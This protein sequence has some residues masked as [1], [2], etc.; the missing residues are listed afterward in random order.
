MTESKPLLVNPVIERLRA[1]DVAMGINIRMS[2]SSDIVRIAKTTG[3][4]FIFIDTQHALFDLQAIGEM[5]HTAQAIGVCPLVRVRSVDD[6]DVSL[7]LDC[8]VQG[9]VFPDVNN[10]AMARKGVETC[11]FAPRGKRSVGGGYMQFDYRALP[12]DQ[13]IG[14]L[15]ESTLVICMIETVE[16]LANVEEIAAVKGVDI[17]HLGT[18][19]LL[20]NMGIPGQFDH[21]KAVEAQNRVIA[22]AKANGIYSGCGGNRDV[23]RQTAAIR[24]GVQFTT[25]QTDTAFLVSAATQWTKS[26]REQLAK[27]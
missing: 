22:A 21:P 7:L 8:G 12:L 26:V 10:A 24:N 2:R 11:R 20:V 1:G 4:D 13:M 17:L 18:N 27:A 3:H 15:D 25:T 23:A 14:A 19:D 5:A 6:P 16:G 9:I